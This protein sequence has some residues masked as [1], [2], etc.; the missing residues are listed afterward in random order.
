[1]AAVGVAN[2]LIMA[3][4]EW[5]MGETNMTPVNT[6]WRIDFGIAGAESTMTMGAMLPRA[7]AALKDTTAAENIPV[8]T[9]ATMIP[10]SRLHT[11]DIQNME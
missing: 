8:E 3:A 6:D 5:N 11:G 1:M 9:C 2:D 7:R 10:I 4:G